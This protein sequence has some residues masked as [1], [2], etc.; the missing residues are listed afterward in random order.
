MYLCRG[1]RASAQLCFLYQQSCDCEH[2]CM[3]LF[4]PLCFIPMFGA[5]LSLLCSCT[6][7]PREHSYGASVAL[8][9]ALE[10]CIAG[11]AT[12]KNI[13]DMHHIHLLPL[14]FPCNTNKPST[15]S[16]NYQQFNTCHCLI[17]FE[18]KV[19]AFF[20]RSW[21]CPFKGAKASFALIS[22]SCN[23]QTD[24][25][26][27]HVDVWTCVNLV[28]HSAIKWFSLE[29]DDVDAN[30]TMLTNVT[31]KF[32]ATNGTKANLLTERKLSNLN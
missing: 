20:S 27:I 21:W 3:W 18:C 7:L 28:S 15:H 5:E 24:S 4:I 31:E 2:S 10:T 8:A 29:A 6:T 1:P 30:V 25:I 22:R 16:Y 13:Y 23:S 32:K 17:S 26:I 9:F 19:D 11:H 12:C 14:K